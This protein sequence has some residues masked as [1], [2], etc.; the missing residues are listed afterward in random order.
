MTGVTKET[1]SDLERGLRHPHDPTLAKIAQGYGVPFEELIGEP[2]PLDEAPEEGTGPATAE[3]TPEAEAEEISEADRICLSDI[4]D[5]LTAKMQSLLDTYGPHIRLLSIGP[6]SA[7][8]S[9]DDPPPKRLSE[10]F[11][12]LT[13]FRLTCKHVED[14]VDGLASSETVNPWVA[15]MND[16]ATPV[17][18]RKKLR[19]FETAREELFDNLEP[20]AAAWMDANRKYLPDEGLAKLNAEEGYLPGEL[21]KLRR[22]R[23]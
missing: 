3:E 6:P 19:D 5:H 23:S 18:I 1:I 11:A 9:P 17:D 15:R 10:T 2:V 20:Y 8:T 21:A 16:E 13:R 12:G 7:N 4:L 14:I 22:D